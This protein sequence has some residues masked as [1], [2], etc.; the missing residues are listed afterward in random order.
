M[1]RFGFLGFQ[2]RVTTMVDEHRPEWRNMAPIS[3]RWGR[4][5]SLALTGPFQNFHLKSFLPC[6]SLNKA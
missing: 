3:E 2:E 5:S 1:Q 6:K 4:L